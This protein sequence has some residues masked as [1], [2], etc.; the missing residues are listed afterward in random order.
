M[1]AKVAVIIPG[2]GKGARFGGGEN[3]T[4]RRRRVMSISYCAAWLRP[5]ENSFLNVSRETAHALEPH[6]QAIL[7]Y[8]SHDATASGGGMIGLFENGDPMRALD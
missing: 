6:M 2:A 1:S 3:K 8:A 4:D 7:G 5:V